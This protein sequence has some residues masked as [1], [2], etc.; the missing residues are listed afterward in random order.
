MTIKERADFIYALT[1]RL[2]D[3]VSEYESACKSAIKNVHSAYMYA[4][5]LSNPTATK[6]AIKRRILTLRQELNTL[7]KEL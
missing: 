6:A 3:D 5:Y 7:S 2:K 4:D 1:D